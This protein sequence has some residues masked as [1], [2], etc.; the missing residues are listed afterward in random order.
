MEKEKYIGKSTGLA[1]ARDNEI[2]VS[3]EKKNIEISTPKEVSVE[4]HNSGLMNVCDEI[5]KQKVIGSNVIIR[6][7]LFTDPM[8]DALYAKVPTESGTKMDA[9]RQRPYQDYGILVAKGENC[10]A[11][12]GVKVGSKVRVHP[13]VSG[14]KKVQYAFTTNGSDFDNYFLMN[15]NLIMSYE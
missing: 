4:E 10:T 13:S 11:L 12:K 5:R 9:V 2:R 8:V 15:E 14:E 7:L 1:G 3:G 6:F